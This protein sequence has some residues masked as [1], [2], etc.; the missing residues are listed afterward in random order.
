MATIGVSQASADTTT[1]A[2]TQATQAKVAVVG[3]TTDK[4]PE[5]ASST[6]PTTADT[7]E[8]PANTTST[9]ETS[10]S[11]DVGVQQSSAVNQTTSEATN[12]QPTKPTNEQQ[13]NS[14]SNTTSTTTVVNNGVDKPNQAT[15]GTTTPVPDTT[16]SD[17]NSKAFDTTTKADTQTSIKDKALY[18][19]KIAVKQAPVKNG[20]VSENGRTFYYDNNKI[21]TGEKKIDNN[22]YNFDKAGQYSIG[23]TNLLTKTVFYDNNGHMYYGYLKT[24]NTYMYFDTR[25]GHAV[26]GERYYGNHQME[27]Y[28]QDFKQVRNAYVRTGNTYYFIGQYGDA[29]SGERYYGNH[30]MEYYGQ[31]FKQVRNVYVRTGNTYYFMGQY[32]DAV[33]GERYY[34]NHSMEYYGQDFKQVRNAYVRTGNTYYFIGQYGDAVTGLRVYGNRPNQVEYYDK[35]NFKQVRNANINEAGK[36]YRF[37]GNGDLIVANKP[38]YFSQLDWHWGSH[39]FNAYTMAQAGCVPTSLAMVLNGSYGM[40][41][42]PDDVKSVMD[43]LSTFGYGATGADLINTANAYGHKVNRL[44]TVA[45]TQEALQQGIP[46]IFFVEVAGGYGHAIVAYGYNS[47]NGTTEI[48]DPY[49]RYYYNGWYNVANVSQHLST[50]VGDW[51]VGRPVFAIM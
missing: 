35:N 10:K 28:G 34:G 2:D 23:L 32:G 27:Y 30:S 29:V 22:W 50:D 11:A 7:T 40:N 26:T 14:T 43:N 46:V 42:S 25:D 33:T 47:S 3:T 9:T 36:S 51:N 15:N 1:T 39:R 41:V 16:T 31:D 5:T 18:S 6:K 44:D 20:W 48:L 24:D 8:I 37:G 4:A 13:N 45:H 12:E 19:S 38:T 49:N 21:V 17:D